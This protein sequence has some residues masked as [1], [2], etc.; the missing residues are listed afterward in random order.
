MEDVIRTFNPRYWEYDFYVDLDNLGVCLMSVSNPDKQKLFVRRS[1]EI[2]DSRWMVDQY[3]GKDRW[4]ATIACDDRDSAL[5]EV[6]NIRARWAY[7]RN[8]AKI[9]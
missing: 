9:T 2:N 1:D 3:D 4:A 8:R 7:K 5:R 6:R